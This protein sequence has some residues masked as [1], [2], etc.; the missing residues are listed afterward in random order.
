MDVTALIFAAAGLWI[1]C[2]FGVGT[3]G[4]QTYIPVTLRR[5]GRELK[6]LALRDTG[7]TLRDPITGEPVLVAGT[8]VATEL[9]GLT[10]YQI[11]HPV[12]TLARGAVPGLRLIPYH[13]VG[14]SGGMML[15]LRMKDTSV[16]K[17]RGDVIVAFAPEKI[18][19]GEMYRMLTGGAV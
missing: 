12:E 6:V 18:G 19:Q 8:D 9:L 2:R 17:I 13:S 7:N 14:R 4:E 3:V 5:D 16:G 1:L 15:A 10:E 11:A